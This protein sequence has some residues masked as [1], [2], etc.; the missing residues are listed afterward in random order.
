MN[1]D[2]LLSKVM[3]GVIIGTVLSSLI[4]GLLFLALAGRDG[5]VNGL[6]LGGALGLVGS[7]LSAALFDQPFWYEIVRRVG[8]KR[9]RQ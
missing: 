6:I 4:V 2:K 8:D 5:L 3:F 9:H 1:S 7:L